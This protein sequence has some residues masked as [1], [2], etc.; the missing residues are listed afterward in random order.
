MKN[1]LF[2]ALTILC[3]PLWA[4]QRAASKID[5]QL[6]MWVNNPAMLIREQPALF[7]NGP[8]ADVMISLLF[9]TSSPAPRKLAERFG[10]KLYSQIGSICTAEI[11]LKQIEAFA[12]QAEVI[13]IESSQPVELYNDKGIQHIRADSVHQGFL[14]EQLPYTGKGVLVGIVDTGIDFLH[15]DFMQKNDS[16]KTRIVS[17]WDQTDHSGTPP[18]N[19]TYGS[20]WDAAQVQAALTNPALISQRDSSG[21]GT[22]VSGTSAGLRG[23]AFDAEIIS[24]KTPLVS[25]GDYKFSTSAKTLDAVKFI[26]DK[27]QQLQ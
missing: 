10:G 18:A 19:F 16:T 23:V 20:A 25:N 6:K 17:I 12:E 26:Y 15:P 14:P 1:S 3:L 8:V 27:A 4:Q 22:H 7:K 9:K 13:K 2:I 11:P 5:A 24:V 21:H